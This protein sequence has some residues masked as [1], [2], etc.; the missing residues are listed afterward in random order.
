MKNFIEDLKRRVDESSIV[1]HGWPALLVFLV[2]A[3]GLAAII[4]DI[5]G[6]FI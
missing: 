6:W 3:R 4:M 2:L 5:V 1:A